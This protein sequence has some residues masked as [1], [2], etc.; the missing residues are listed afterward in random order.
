MQSFVK[1]NKAKHNCAL[2]ARDL[3]TL[4]LCWQR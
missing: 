3:A 1:P 4:G 2:R